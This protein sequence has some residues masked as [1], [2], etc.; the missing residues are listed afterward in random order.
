MRRTLVILVLVA[1]IGAIGWWLLQWEGAPSAMGDPWEHLP[2]NAAVV[3]EINDPLAS[4]QRFT[5]TSQWWT[6][7]DAAPGPAA[8]DALMDRAQQAADKDPAIKKALAGS[9]LFISFSSVGEGVDPLLIWSLPADKNAKQ[10]LGDILG[11]DGGSNA[12]LWQTGRATTVEQ[13]GIPVLYLGYADGLVFISTASNALDGAL[14]YGTEHTITLGADSTFMQARASLGAGSDAHVLVNI[15]RAQRL[16]TTWLLPKTL[17][18]LSTTSGWVA[19]D[20]RLRPEALLLSGF[21]IPS[22]TASGTRA[23]AAQES[24]SFALGRTLHPRVEEVT[25]YSISDP[26]TYCTAALGTAPDPALFD[27]YGAW[28]HGAMGKAR[29]GTVSD[30]TSWV[31]ALLQTEDPARAHAALLARCSSCDTV[32]YRGVRMFHSSDTAA[33]STVWGALFEDIEQPWWCIL[34]DK[35]IFADRA[36]ALRLSIDAWTDGYSLV[37]DTRTGGFFKRYASDAGFTWWCDA[38]AGLSSLQDDMKP[39]GKQAW[40]DHQKAWDQLGGCLVQLTPETNGSFQVSACLASTSSA[41]INTEDTTTTSQSTSALWSVSLGASAQS[42]PWLLTD[43]LSR[44]KQILVQDSKNRISLISCTGK[45]MWQRELDGPILGDVRQV[46][47]FKNGKLQMLFN[48]ESRIHLI[49]RNGK[50]VERFPIAISEK[51]SAPLNV[52]DYEGKKEYRILIPTVEASLLNFDMNGKAVEGWA[53]PKTTTTC[54][55]PVEHLRIRGKDYLILVDKKG[56]VTALDRRGEGRYTPK[57]NVQEAQRLIGLVPAMDIGDCAVLWNDADG[58]LLRGKFN[59]EVDTLR[60]GIA[61]AGGSALDTNDPRL[62]G[63]IFFPDNA[64]EAKGRTRERTADINLDGREERIVV[65]EDGHVEVTNT[66]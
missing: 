5:S 22:R 36:G 51:A 8:F 30:T 17:N 28:V 10:G 47:K 25:Q 21:M 59:G 35:V 42:G 7:W 63:V 32:S 11:A 50:D 34:K 20:A 54:E 19:L 12:Q 38:A 65:Q 31:W 43:H 2:I 16:L 52:F 15:E 66:P 49:D 40:A 53:P 56:G 24:T 4:W 23:M 41:P 48:T 6:A 3:V 45:M 27:A 14:A 55:V 1:I 29:L 60:A 37:Q 62:K 9:S 26:L 58:D 64:A 46:D 33:L 13:K 18:A 61:I 39:K 44:T 57:L